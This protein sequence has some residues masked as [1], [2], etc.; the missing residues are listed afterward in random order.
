MKLRGT[1]FFLCLIILDYAFGV[2][3]VRIGGGR[4]TAMGNASVANQDAWSVFNN[5]AG[6]SWVNG[7]EIGIGYENRYLMKELGL[8]SLGI[9]LPLKN[10]GFGISIQHFGFSKYNEMKVGIAYSMKFGKN[11]ST[12]IQLD[13]FRIGQGENYGNLNLLSFEAGIQFKI[14]T[15]WRL[16]V[17]IANPIPVRLTKIQQEYLPTIFRLGL[18]CIFS[19]TFNLASEVETKLNFSPILKMG[20][21]YHPV[22]PVFIRVGFLTHPGSSLLEQDGSPPGHPIASDD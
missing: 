7:I 13:Y 12:G 17:H 1:I 8:K 18:A 14:D 9:V 5:Q 11:F 6:L 16:G 2:E 21:E 20:F 19:E 10:K 3:P 15:R 22:K 4:A